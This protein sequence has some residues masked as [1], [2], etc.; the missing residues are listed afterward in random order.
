M[1][2]EEFIR[3]IREKKREMYAVAYS[4]LQNHSDVEDVIQD[5]IISA[6]EK[7]ST[8][9]DDKKINSWMMRIIVNQ[10]KMY[11]R[12]NS[13]LRYVAFEEAQEEWKD[14]VGDD[15]I[16]DVVMSLKKEFRTVVV[17]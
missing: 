16:W 8:L 12:K 3:Y 2:K 6:Y 15:N 13:R 14:R 10:S 5:A 7:L 1:E 17:L 9:K 11:L 4:V